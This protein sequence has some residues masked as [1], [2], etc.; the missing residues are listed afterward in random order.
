MERACIRGDVISVLQLIHT[1]SVTIHEKGHFGSALAAAAAG[2]DEAIVLILLDEGVD[3]DAQN[4]RYGHVVIQGG[5]R[6]MVKLLLDHGA[7]INVQGLKPRQGTPLRWAFTLGHTSIVRLLLE[8]GAGLEATFLEDEPSLLH[9]ATARADE[10]MVQLLLDHGADV[11]DPNEEALVIAAEM[12]HVAI[13]QMLLDHGMSLENSGKGWRT[14]L[15]AAC[16]H[17]SIDVARLLIDRGADVNA[18][19]HEN[20]GALSLL[21]LP[22]A[23]KIWSVCCFAAVSTLIQKVQIVVLLYTLQQPTTVHPSSNFFS[24]TARTWMPPVE[25]AVQLSRQQ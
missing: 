2:R 19:G 11:H 15:E 5:D 12:N 16:A 9:L 13:T 25:V 3:T 22:V 4:E 14:A 7:S 18:H 10:D 17:H 6:E 21:Q 24:T 23:L 20:V 8:R 1:N